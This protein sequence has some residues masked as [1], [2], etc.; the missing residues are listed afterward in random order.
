MSRE[1]IVPDGMQAMYDNFHFAPAVRS[2]KFVFCSGQI[3]IGPDGTPG[4]SAPH[5]PMRPQ[6]ADG[7]K[8]N[9]CRGTDLRRDRCA[10]TRPSFRGRTGQVPAT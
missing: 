6:R 8:K 3:G 9:W 5:D 4:R 7:L 2:G 10:M 1:T